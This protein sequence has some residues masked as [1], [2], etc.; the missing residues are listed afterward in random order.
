MFDDPPADLEVGDG[1]YRVDVL[2]Y[3]QASFPDDI[4]DFSDERKNGFVRFSS[5]SSPYW[6]LRRISSSSI[7]SRSR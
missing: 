1:L 5:G 6:F 2:C 4:L 3:G 7:G